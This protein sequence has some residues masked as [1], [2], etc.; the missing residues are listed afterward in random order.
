MG[1]DCEFFLCLVVIRL[2]SVVIAHGHVSL[3]YQLFKMSYIPIDREKVVFGNCIDSL[4]IVVR[5]YR[6]SF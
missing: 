2:V 6:I 1:V 5:I 3:V 4:V